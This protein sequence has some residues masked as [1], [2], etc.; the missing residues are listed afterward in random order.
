MFCMRAVL[1]NKWSIPAN[2]FAPTQSKNPAFAGFNNPRRRVLQLRGGEFI[3]ERAEDCRM[4]SEFYLPLVLK[5]PLRGSSLRLGMKGDC[6]S[7]RSEESLCPVL[8]H[9]QHLH[10]RRDVGLLAEAPDE[11]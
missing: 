3:R 7:E 11:L 8:L 10:Q 5:Q 1:T 4:R 6:H 9:P 2:E